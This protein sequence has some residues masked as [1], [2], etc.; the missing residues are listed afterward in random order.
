MTSLFGVAGLQVGMPGIFA[1]VAAVGWILG[2]VHAFRTP[3][4]LF[5]SDLERI[6][7]RLCVVLLGLLGTI[8]WFV[9]FRPALRERALDLADPGTRPSR[10]WA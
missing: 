6:A 4:H 3:R 1:V 8:G 10:P 2:V 9:L 7:V 5:V